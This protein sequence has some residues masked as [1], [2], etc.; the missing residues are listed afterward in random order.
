MTASPR[1][2]F[3]C[4]Y[5]AEP[6]DAEL[7][8]RMN[9]TTVT[10]ASLAKA[11]EGAHAR[12]LAAVA[13]DL[14]AVRLQIRDVPARPPIER[15][16]RMVSDILPGYNNALRRPHYDEPELRGLVERGLAEARHLAWSDFEVEAKHKNLASA[17]LARYLERRAAAPRVA[18]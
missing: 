7:S 9:T 4:T 14:S 2:A 11:G 18:A 1:L 3:C 6:E 12:L 16:F 15:A 8:R 13:H 10:M 5:V 17:H